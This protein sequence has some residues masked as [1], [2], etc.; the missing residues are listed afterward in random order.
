[1]QLSFW[2]DESPVG[3]V[4]NSVMEAEEALGV[5]LDFTET[6]DGTVDVWYSDYDEG[7]SLEAVNARYTAIIDWFCE[8]RPSVSYELTES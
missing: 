1:M 6:E 7:L 2:D 4:I 5:P 3:E 8:N